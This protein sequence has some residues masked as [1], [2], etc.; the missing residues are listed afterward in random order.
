M[1]A[2]VAHLPKRQAQAAPAAKITYDEHVRPIFREHC[3]TCHAQ[4]AD[5]GGLTLDT[6]AKAMAGGSSGEVDAAWRSG[7]FAAVGAGQPHR[8]AGNA[9]DAGQA[10]RRPSST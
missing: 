10:G 7:Q 6:Y 5:K 1:A 3:F 4:E 2:I 9:A 8:E